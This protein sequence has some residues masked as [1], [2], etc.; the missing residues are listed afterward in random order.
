MEEGERQ[1]QQYYSMQEHVNNP[2]NQPANDQNRPINAIDDRSIVLRVLC[3]GGRAPPQAAQRGQEEPHHWPQDQ[4]PRDPQLSAFQRGGTRQQQQHHLSIV[5]C[6]RTRLLLL[7]LTLLFGFQK[8]KRTKQV[9]RF[10]ISAPR[11]DDLYDLFPLDDL[12][13]SG[14]IYF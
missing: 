3:L 5:H 4:G 9:R 2:T 7:L 1:Q 13:L 14:W 6:I 11:T 8:R 10:N 12:D